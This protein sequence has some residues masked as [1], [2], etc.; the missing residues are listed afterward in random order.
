MLKELLKN[1][2]FVRYQILILPILSF[3]ITAG[4][5]F[6]VIIPQVG[7]FLSVRQGLQ[8][9]N[10]KK[11][12]LIQKAEVLEN[13]NTNT[14]KDNIQTSLVALPED[15]DIPQAIGQLL[16]LLNSNRLQ[17]D[18][19]KFSNSAG[20][21]GKSKSFQVTFDVTGSYSSVQSFLSGIKTTPRLM[22]INSI[23]V[24]SANNKVQ[25]TLGV[26]VYYQPL[27]SI[28][29]S[30]DQ[31]LPQLTGKDL[32]VLAKYQAFVTQP[33]NTSVGG[34]KGKSDPFE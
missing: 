34:A 4:L 3:F 21:D 19:V 32:E 26:E 17:L 5:I 14:F 23:Q 22:K 7:E 12:F 15:R 11:E 27:P 6:F 33:I 2:Y 24:S 29:G 28:I 8:E 1:K 10:L 9:A 13:T 16:F 20:D 30:V 25:A 18:D 31:K